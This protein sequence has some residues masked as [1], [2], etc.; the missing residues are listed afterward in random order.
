MADLCD[1]AARIADHYHRLARR[2]HAARHAVTAA[3]GDGTC[4]DCAEPIEPERLAVQPNA[5][6]CVDCAAEAER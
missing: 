5:L 3:A 2:R 1:D 4:L 6:R